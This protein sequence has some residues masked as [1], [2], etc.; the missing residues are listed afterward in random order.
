MVHLQ[1]HDAALEKLPSKVAAVVPGEQLAQALSAAGLSAKGARFVTFAE[2]ASLEALQ[3][4]HASPNFC[5]IGQHC[6][7]LRSLHIHA[8]P[9]RPCITYGY[10]ACCDLTVSNRDNGRSARDV[11]DADW[12]PFSE[13]ERQAC[14][15][16]I[17]SGLSCTTELAEAGSFALQGL[18]R[19]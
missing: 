16:S 5:Q 12:A 7:I 19:K 6:S 18:V 8:A 15:V 4:G 9:L 3:V 10:Q 13:A 17:G 11:Q 2:L 14:G 1:G